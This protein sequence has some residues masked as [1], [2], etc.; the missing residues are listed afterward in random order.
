VVT[1][2]AEVACV[3]CGGGHLFEDCP[4]NPVSVNYVANYSKHNNPYSATYSPG[5]KNHPNFS[6]TAP[7]NQQKAPDVPPGFAAQGNSQLETVLKNFMQETQKFA[8]DSKNQ[9][10]AQGVSIK[11]LVNQIRQ[12]ANALS[13]RTT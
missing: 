11:N 3:Y 6:W 4:G 8:V 2:S 7:Q 10:L 13:S 9:I 1:D 12:I 5:W